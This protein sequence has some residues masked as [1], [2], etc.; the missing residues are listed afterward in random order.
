MVA[1]KDMRLVTSKDTIMGTTSDTWMGARAGYQ[2][3]YSEG[4]ENGY[5]LGF[6]EGR[7]LG[8]ENGYGEGYSEGYDSGYGKGYSDG[9]DNGY[10]VGETQGYDNGY[11]VGHADGYTTGYSEGYTSGYD[12]GLDVGRTHGYNIHDPTYEEMKDFITRD[13][14]DENT[15]NINTYTC[16]NFAADV[17]NNAKAENIRCALVYLEFSNG[18]HTIVAFDTIDRGRIFIEPQTDEEVSVNVGSP[19]DH[20]PWGNILR[21]VII[22]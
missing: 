19:Y 4:Q 16:I 1:P 18:A 14:T 6:S 3:G 17:I 15:Y 11:S 20:Q 9:Y 10:K 5:S 2:L 7:A 8:Y 22:W 12:N 21:M 13:K